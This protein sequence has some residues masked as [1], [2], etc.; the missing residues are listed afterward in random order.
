[1]Q[2]HPHQMENT[3]SHRD[4]RPWISVVAFAWQ[5]S[6]VQVCLL[7]GK[8][9][10]STSIGNKVGFSFMKF[11][12]FRKR[13]P[14][15]FLAIHVLGLPWKM[16]ETAYVVQSILRKGLIISRMDSVPSWYLYMTVIMHF[17]CN[18]PYFVMNTWFCLHIQEKPRT[19]VFNPSSARHWLVLFYFLLLNLSAV[20]W[21]KSHLQQ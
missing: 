2:L 1:M 3:S 7:A 6:G 8:V 19:F 10:K 13:M 16:G 18:H 14:V 9:V 15:I 17:G 5:L 4:K 11:C 21:L 20:I 12:S